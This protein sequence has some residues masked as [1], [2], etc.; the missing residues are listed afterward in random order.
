[1]TKKEFDREIQQQII[2]SFQ[3]DEWHQLLTQEHCV[4]ISL[5][6]D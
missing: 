5:G 4:H 1:M 3:S 2:Y 6:M